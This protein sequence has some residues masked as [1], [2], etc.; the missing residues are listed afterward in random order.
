MSKYQRELLEKQKEIQ[1]IEEQKR[2]Q[3]EKMLVESNRAFS[4]EEL[5]LVSNTFYGDKEILLTLRKFLLQ[6]TLTQLEKNKLEPIAKNDQIMDI[7]RRS[8]IPVIEPTSPYSSDIW[9]EVKTEEKGAGEAEND[10]LSLLVFIHYIE[11]QLDKMSGKEIKYDYAKKGSKNQWEN[12]DIRFEDLTP[13]GDEGYNN[14]FINLQA[15][16]KI[17]EKVNSTLNQLNMFAI[18]HHIV[19]P[20]EEEKIKELN[21]NK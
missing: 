9:L 10:I 16:N 4:Q 13:K 2:I 6:G 17:I 1:A 20:E 3:I 19:D 21:S 18:Q 15:R 5:S 11:Q 7:I 14:S 8:L 12:G